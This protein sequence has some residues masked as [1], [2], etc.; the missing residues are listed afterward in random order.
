MQTE[1]SPFKNLTPDIHY[2]EKRIEVIYCE[3]CADS[4]PHVATKEVTLYFN[5]ME[6][7]EI[8]CSMGKGVPW[9]VCDEHAEVL[10]M[11]INGEMTTEDEDGEISP[12]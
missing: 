11:N 10:K 1:I 6:N 12:L 2:H 5:P 7:E 8:A 9:H 3:M 4:D